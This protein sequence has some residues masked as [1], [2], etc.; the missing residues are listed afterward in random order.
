MWSHTYTA[1]ANSITQIFPALGLNAQPWLQDPDA[2]TQS[3]GG[4]PLNLDLRCPHYLDTLHRFIES[5][6]YIYIYIYCLDILHR[7]CIFSI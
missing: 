5:S 3:S 2:P 1:I 6:I 4:A 7:I